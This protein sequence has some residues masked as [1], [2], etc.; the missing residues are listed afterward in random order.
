MSLDEW[1]LNR[2]QQY[3]PD[4][5][6]GQGF[7]GAALSERKGAD[8][9]RHPRVKKRLTVRFG[10]GD[11]AHTGYSQDVSE[12]GLYLQANMTFPPRT[13]LQLQIDYPEKTLTLRGIVRWSKELPPAFKRNL[14]GGMGVEF[15]AA[16]DTRAAVKPAESP[17]G[18]APS[19]PAS[20]GSPVEA[21]EKELGGGTTKHRQVSTHGG[22][23]F[24][25]LQTEFRG[26]IYVRIYPLP[27]TDGSAEALFSQAFWKREEAEAAIRAFLRE[28]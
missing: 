28:R 20:T 7:F 24:E 2:G 6:R 14:K 23:T 25:V 16:G 8:R 12:S 19:H 21:S 18:A 9:R 22:R 10:L 4:A 27:R 5:A 3:A 11:L 1:D 15:T 13:V 26:A 17:S